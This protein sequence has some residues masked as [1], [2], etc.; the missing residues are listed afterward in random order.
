MFYHII[1]LHTIFAGTKAPDGWSRAKRVWISR[2]SLHRKC[3]TGASKNGRSWPMKKHQKWGF[4]NIQHVEK[5]GFQGFHRWVHWKST[6]FLS[7]CNYDKERD[8]DDLAGKT[9]GWTVW[10]TWGFKNLPE[11]RWDFTHRFF[12]EVLR[13]VA[14]KTDHL[15]IDISGET[16]IQERTPRTRKLFLWDVLFETF[17]NQYPHVFRSDDWLSMGL[18]ANGVLAIRRDSHH[19]SHLDCNLL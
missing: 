3:P 2:C 11:K 14:L 7:I 1:R 4:N 9:G 8:F 10:L 19:F 6:D 12:V 17:Q 13:I 15:D 5:A 16:G 18:S